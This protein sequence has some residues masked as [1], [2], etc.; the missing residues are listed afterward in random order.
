MYGKTALKKA[1]MLRAEGRRNKSEG[2]EKRR[3]AGQNLLSGEPPPP[4]DLEPLNKSSVGVLNPCSLRS[5][6]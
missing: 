3:V 5:H 1:A 6:F 4:P 2:D